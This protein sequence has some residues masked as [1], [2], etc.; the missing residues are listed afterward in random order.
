[1]ESLTLLIIDPLVIAK[2]QKKPR[3]SF[4]KI[5]EIMPVT[6]VIMLNIPSVGLNFAN[7]MLTKVEIMPVITVIMLNI[8]SVGLNF[9]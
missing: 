2:N 1:M 8:P 7:I 3:G 9:A 6:T 5:T 4:P